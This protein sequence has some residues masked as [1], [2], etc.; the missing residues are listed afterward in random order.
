MEP[1]TG[2]IV[3]EQ[4]AEFPLCPGCALPLARVSWHKIRGGPR[5]VAYT[6]LLSCAG[7]RTL[8]D[9]LSSGAK[10]AAGAAG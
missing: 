10:H 5:T 6:V 8:L 9:V 1:F 2:K 3:L 7:C 4:R